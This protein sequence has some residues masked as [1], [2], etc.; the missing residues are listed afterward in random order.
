MLLHTPSARR[1]PT[2]CCSPQ[3]RKGGCARAYL[4]MEPAEEVRDK[5]ER[6]AAEPGLLLTLLGLSSSSSVMG[7]AA[8]AATE[9]MIK[10]GGAHA[11]RQHCGL[12]LHAEDGNAQ[13]TIRIRWLHA[14]LLQLVL[15]KHMYVY[16]SLRE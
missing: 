12:R 6:A 16:T 5:T 13:D 8:T 10:G 3:G 7:D 2:I 1:T 15:L 11:A 9:L 4:A 14:V